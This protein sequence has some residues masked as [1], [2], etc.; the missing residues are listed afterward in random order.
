MSNSYSI[1]MN[2]E[3]YGASFARSAIAMAFHSQ[4]HGLVAINQNSLSINRGTITDIKL[5][6]TTL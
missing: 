1:G 3:K 6:K 2:P 5:Q 4:D